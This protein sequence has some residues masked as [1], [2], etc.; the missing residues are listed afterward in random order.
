[1]E[2]V[3][4]EVAA[5]EPILLDAIADRGGLNRSLEAFAV[6]LVIALFFFFPAL[7]KVSGSLLICETISYGAETH[8]YLVA[9][10]SIDCDTSEYHLY[11]AYAQIVLIATAF[12]V[13][14]MLVLVVKLVQFASLKGDAAAANALFFFSTGGFRPTLWFWEAVITVRKGMLIGLSVLVVVVQ[15]RG[16]VCLWVTLIALVI[17]TKMQP[18]ADGRLQNL[19][20]LSLATLSVTY[21]LVLFIP[22][23]LQL[24]GSLITITVMCIIV[25]SIALLLFSTIL[26]TTG[27][28]FVDRLVKKT[29]ALS[30]FRWLFDDV[31]VA[32][33]SA[34]ETERTQLIEAIELYQGARGIVRTVMDEELYPAK[35]ADATAAQLESAGFLQYERKLYFATLAMRRSSAPKE[36][37]LALWKAETELLQRVAQKIRRATIM[38]RF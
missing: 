9:D 28:E 31:P 21:G 8:R 7:L 32:D 22:V 12:G 17:H 16:Y 20:T 3:A 37:L 18:Y 5:R 13:P 33:G 38:K 24:S 36:A 4:V 11:R 15:L 34:D 1:V 29:P 23:T 25:N 2:E 26:F 30:S 14:A 6:T 19:E 10:R 35:F 27:I